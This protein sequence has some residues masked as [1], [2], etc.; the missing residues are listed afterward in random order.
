MTQADP[1]ETREGG[2]LPPDFAPSVVGTV[3]V[4]N[5]GQG[6]RY[7]RHPETRALTRVQ[8]TETCADCAL[9][10]GKKG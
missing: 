4:I 7:I 6:G 2:L 9:P 10:P 3:P 1:T 8:H 5:P